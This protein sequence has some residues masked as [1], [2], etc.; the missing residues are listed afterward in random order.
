MGDARDTDHS[1]SA[2]AAHSIASRSSSP[3][4]RAR[5]ATFA[6][7][8]ESIFALPAGHGALAGMRWRRE[9]IHWCARAAATPRSC[10]NLSWMHLEQ[11]L[12]VDRHSQFTRA[13]YRDEPLAIAT[14]TDSL[15]S[16]ANVMPCFCA[17]ACQRMRSVSVS[18]MT[19]R[20]RARLEWGMRRVSTAAAGGCYVAVPSGI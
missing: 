12:G 16:S 1:L 4:S 9:R 15:T 18:S 5:S 11:S 8:I 14:S 13:A 3:S 20:V 2:H 19:K 7:A 10:M 17:S 6:L